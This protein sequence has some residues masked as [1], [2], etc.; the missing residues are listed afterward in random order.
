MN[1]ARTAAFFRRLAK[2]SS[3][4]WALRRL[5]ETDAWHAEQMSIH[6]AEL[7]RV[8]KLIEHSA[9]S[10]GIRVFLPHDDP[11]WKNEFVMSEL[12]RTGFIV[13]SMRHSTQGTIEWWCDLGKE[14]T[15]LK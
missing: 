6:K 8:Y 2:H 1:N 15:E 11:V 12:R 13:S 10:G 4:K 14:K 3:E 5:V 9:S 7:D